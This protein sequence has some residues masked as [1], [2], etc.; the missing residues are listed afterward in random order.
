MDIK[1]KEITLVKINELIPYKKN[2]NS[3]SDEQ[4]GRLIKIIEYQGFRNPVIAQK[5]TNVIAS[6][7]GRIMAAKKMGMTHVPVIYQEFKNE[8]EFYSY[9]VSDNAIAEWSDLDL[10]AINSEMLDLG[11]D[12]D[13]DLLGIKDFV[14]EPVEKFEP[15]GD[16]DAVPEAPV[17]PVTKR[18]DVWILGKHR[19]MCG[20][21]TMIDD[22][23]KLMDGERADMLFT[24][25]PYGV[26]YDGGALSKREKL[27]NDDN[28]DMYDLPLKNACAFTTESASFYIWFSDSKPIETV[29]GVEGAGLKIRNWIIWNKNV[30]QFGALS[31][32]YK[33]KHEPC[34]YAFKKGKKANWCGPTNEVTVW[35][36][37]RDNKNNFHPTQKP[38][39]LSERAF[40][41]HS[42]ARVLD[43]FG[44]SGSTLISC[45]KNNKIN[46]TM[47]YSESY[48]DVIVKR[49][50]EY[51]GK[52][53]VLESTGETF[54]QLNLTN[55]GK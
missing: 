30:A 25:P 6:G 9:V 17:E 35:D 45:E 50:Q 44:G 54:Q 38:I 4:I 41:N 1:S 27:A 40:S 21:S 31:A 39:A 33:T 48:C 2:M 16:E 55:S 18:G 13:I 46:F 51:T 42:V 47:E 52:E 36:I 43:L 5:G 14:I 7:H 26:D 37:S 49:W 19:L 10:G 20:D 8:E 15:Q 12:F 23:E 3:H 34:I 53:A 11:P 22:V 24:D 29:T 28:V 32:Q